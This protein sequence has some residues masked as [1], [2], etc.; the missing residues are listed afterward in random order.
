MI[1]RRE[2]D[3]SR[4]AVF[5]PAFAAREGGL[6]HRAAPKPR[7]RILL[8]FFSAAALL[9]SGCVYLRLLQLKRQLADFD[10]HFTVQLTSGLRLNCLHPVVLADDLR[11]LGFYP[12]NVRKLGTAEQ[13]TIR[14]IKEPPANVR[15]RQ[16]YEISFDLF[17]GEEKLTALHV[18]D[19]YLA[20]VPKDVIVATVKSLGRGKLD[21]S[22]RSLESDV[23]GDLIPPSAK[24][25]S[26]ML[27][28]P[29]DRQVDG[30]REVFHYH[31]V[32]DDPEHKGKD[33]DLRLTFDN[34]SGDL[35][36]TDAR[37]PVGRL[38]LK[39]D[40]AGESAAKSKP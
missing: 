27:G 18:A 4:S 38:H 34:A 24:G 32:S 12:A 29:T 13:W 30:D 23:L 20:F 35:L 5:Q 10:T 19:K 2:A 14:W 15:E 40:R 25:V 22:S 11:F 21:K 26:E 31:F 7:N 17:F 39:F 3:A 16:R 6:K 28:A 1:G 37:M 8:A 33:C 36:A 9:L